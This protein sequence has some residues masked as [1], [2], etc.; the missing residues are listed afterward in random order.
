MLVVDLTKKRTIDFDLYESQ[1][2]VMKKVWD[3]EWDNALDK[4][5]QMEC[6]HLVIHGFCINCSLFNPRILYY[7]LKERILH[8]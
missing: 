7:E 3:N 8:G 6:G 5:T 2:K 1:K 4:I